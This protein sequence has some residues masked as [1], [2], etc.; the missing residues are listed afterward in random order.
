MAKQDSL[1]KQLLIT[2]PNSP[3]VYR[4]NS[5]SAYFLVSPFRNISVGL[6]DLL[7]RIIWKECWLYFLARSWSGIRPHSYPMEASTPMTGQDIEIITHRVECMKCGKT[8]ES[9]ERMAALLSDDQVMPQ[10]GHDWHQ[11]STPWFLFKVPG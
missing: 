9:P 11:W 2:W 10:E 8:W 6:R 3:R 1:D 4:T 5:M 7:I